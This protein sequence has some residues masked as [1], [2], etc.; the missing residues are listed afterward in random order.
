MIKKMKEDKKAFRDI[1]PRAA[2]QRNK[3]MKMASVNKTLSLPTSN[4]YR[5]IH[6]CISF[7][8]VENG[9]IMAFHFSKRG[10]CTKMYL[11]ILLMYL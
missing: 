2:E 5:N 9:N 10:D 4:I 1:S 3:V 6:R 8:A 11:R 7:L